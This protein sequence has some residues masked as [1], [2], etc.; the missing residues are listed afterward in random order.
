M[1]INQI[2]ERTGFYEWWAA[3]SDIRLLAKKY[4]NSYSIGIFACCRELFSPLR[5]CGL[6]KGTKQEALAHFTERMTT[7]VESLRAEESKAKEEA[8]RKMNELQA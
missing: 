4:S 1:L 6:F 7:L 2:N 5:H 8:L 3:E